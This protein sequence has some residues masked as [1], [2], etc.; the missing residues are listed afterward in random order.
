MKTLVRM[1]S[2]PAGAKFT[3]Q[4][5]KRATFLH[6]DEKYSGAYVCRFDDNGHVTAYAGCAE[7]F[8]DEAPWTFKSLPPITVDEIWEGQGGAMDPEVM[9]DARRHHS[10]IIQFGPSATRGKT[11]MKAG[12]R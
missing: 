8:P 1:D 6:Q 7:V 2:L 12:D 4:G 5:G 10:D 3:D 9:D 11:R